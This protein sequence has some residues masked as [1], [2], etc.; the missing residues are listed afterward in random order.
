[1]KFAGALGAAVALLASPLHA[2]DV[3]SPANAWSVIEHPTSGPAA[4]IGEDAN[5]CLAGAKPLP[6]D[7]PGYAVVRLSRNRFFGHPDLVDFIERLG[8]RARTAEL[9]TFYVGDMAQPRG[10]PLPFGHAS[11]QTGLDVDIWFTSDTKPHPDSA[12]RETPELPSMLLPDSSG[13]DPTRFGIRQVK[14]LE[15]AATDERVDRIFVSPVIKLSLC[16]T[17]VYSLATGHGPEWLR[18]LRPWW[19]HDDHFHI[20]L[21]CPAGSPQC[22]SLKPVPAGDGCDN[23]LAAWAHDLTPPPPNGQAIKPTPPAA[24]EAVLHQR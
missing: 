21:A 24:C 23:D 9:P 18:R 15:L 8:Q 6:V 22:A 14:L 1:M 3:P 20:R 17:H 16:R 4:S 5:G 12:E 13:I 10:G 2:S 19:G 7:G 11:H